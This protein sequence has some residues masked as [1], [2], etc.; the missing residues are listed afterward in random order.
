LVSGHAQV[1]G[2]AR[3]SGHAQVYG[4]ARVSGDAQVSGDALVSG[5]AQVYGDARVSGDAWNES[6]LFLLDSRGYGC[7]NCS[8][9]H[10]QI[11]CR[12]LTFAQWQGEAGKALADQNSFTP[13]EIVEYAA[14]VNLF[15]AIGK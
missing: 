12:C 11:G 9:G 8:R 10:L 14:I 13:A 1:S 3:V 5:H 6:P 4:D 2:H 7:T 15:A